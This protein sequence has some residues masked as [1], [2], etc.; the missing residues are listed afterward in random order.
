MNREPTIDCNCCPAITDLIVPTPLR[1]AAE[2]R[3]VARPMD[4]R[5]AAARVGRERLYAQASWDVRRSL[6]N[7]SHRNGC[8]WRI[9]MQRS[10]HQDV[11]ADAAF[12][13]FRGYA[14]FAHDENAVAKMSHLLRIAGIE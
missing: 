13:E 7:V 1:S 8:A 5:R 3:D 10:P 14:A 2:R 6:R 4:A 12:Y 11:A 9:D